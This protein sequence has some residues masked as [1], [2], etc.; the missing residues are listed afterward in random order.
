LEKLL[1]WLDK[2]KLRDT[3]ELEKN[4]YNF[5]SEI[6]GLK[7]EDIFRKQTVETKLTILAAVNRGVTA[8]TAL[9]P[10]KYRLP[11]SDTLAVVKLGTTADITLEFVK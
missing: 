2:E 1:N 8:D 7:K 6:K 4:K 5:I 3:K 9:A 10:V 11:N